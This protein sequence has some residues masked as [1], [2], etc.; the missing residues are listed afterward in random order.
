[1]SI[2]AMVWAINAPVGGNEKV[3]LIGL[4]N[5]ARPDGRGA[6]PSVPLLARY[7]HASPSTVQRALR[8]LESR[9]FAINR[10]LHGPPGR[11]TNAYDLSMD[12]LYGEQADPGQNDRGADPGQ[13]DRGSK[14]ATPGVAG[15]TGEP[16]YNQG[17]ASPRPHARKRAQSARAAADKLPDGYPDELR[18]HAEQAHRVLTD[19]AEQWNAREVTLRGVGLAI[20]GN[21]NRRFV[22]EAF[23][24]ASWAQAPP[25]PIKDVVGTY[26]TWLGKAERIAGV[27][28]LDG[29]PLA[30]GPG[31]TTGR[32]PT[33]FEEEQAGLAAEYERLRA[34]GR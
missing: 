10:G 23:A 5:H 20:M 16:S 9:G 4:A 17:S 31:R 27:E 1:V 14:D 15:V 29:G 18:P 19:I 7:A 2:E 24:L 25:R 13:N 33:R 8:G 21:Q 11:Q 22:Q 6:W 28:R 12:P 26:R 30:A 32:R 34:E 3:V